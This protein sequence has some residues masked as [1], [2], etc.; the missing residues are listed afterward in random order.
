MREGVAEGDSGRGGLDEF[1]GTAGFEH[2][3][4]SGHVGN[5]FYTEVESYKSK[6]EDGRETRGKTRRENDN[7][8]D[9]ETRRGTRIARKSSA[10]IRKREEKS[11]RAARGKGLVGGGEFP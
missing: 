8:K 10:R 2:A 3:G 11:G 7:A 5:S 6:V 1:A 9:A 4:L